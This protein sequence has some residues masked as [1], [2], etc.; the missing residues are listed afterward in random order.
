MKRFILGLD[1]AEPSKE[2]DE[3]AAA[4]EGLSVKAE[5]PVEKVDAAETSEQA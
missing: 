5:E 2:A 4:L 3:A 1:A